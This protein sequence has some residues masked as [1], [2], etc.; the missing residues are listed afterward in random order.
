MITKIIRNKASLYIARF[1]NVYRILFYRILSSNHLFGRDGTLIRRQPVLLVGKGKIIVHGRVS[2]GFFPSPHFYSSYCHLE[3]R[4]EASE[5][6]IG[7]ETHINNN[8]V[9]IA[10]HT[11]I[12]IGS[13]CLFGT[14]V[15][16]IDSD[17]HGLHPDQ[18]HLSSKEWAKP[19]TIGD[20]V[21]IGSNVR[22]LKGSTIGDRSVIANSSVVTGQVPPNAIAGGNPCR[23]IRIFK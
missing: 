1:I 14:G 10:E 20:H 21:F 11:S 17:F 13:H 5:I 23:V 9:A 18:R 6:R 4:N 15:E 16:I 7:H 3:A 22:I 19:V 8:F 2:I 12:S